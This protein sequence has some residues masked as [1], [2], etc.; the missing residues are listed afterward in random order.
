MFDRILHTSFYAV[1]YMFWKP[2]LDQQRAKLTE[3]KTVTSFEN[4]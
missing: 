1:I 2:L 3:K 4:T